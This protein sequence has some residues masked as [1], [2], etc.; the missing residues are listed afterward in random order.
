MTHL[1]WIIL[2]ASVVFAACGRAEPS[3]RASVA[4]ADQPP[5]EV[6][7]PPDAAAA[8]V[9]EDVFEAEAAAVGVAIVAPPEQ[10]EAKDPPSEPSVVTPLPQLCREACANASRLVLAELPV[11][12]AQ[13]MRDEVERALERECPGRCLQRAS[14]ESARCFVGAKSALELA[15][16][17]Q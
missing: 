15:A 4:R 2:S 5:R 7:T 6:N 13:A 17:P 10:V 3:P 9:S 8:L 11:D 12:S 14:V 1:R 16:C